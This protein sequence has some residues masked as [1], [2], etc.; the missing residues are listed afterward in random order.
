MPGVGYCSECDRDVELSEEGVCPQGHSP[1]CISDVREQVIASSPA[2]AEPTARD[3]TRT[4]RRAW[5]WIAA[6]GIAILAVAAMAT[7]RG[8]T[9]VPLAQQPASSAT[10][11][12][13]APPLQ[14]SIQNPSFEDWSGATPSNWLLSSTAP[15]E[16]TTERPDWKQSGACGAALQNSSDDECDVTELWQPVAITTGEQYRASVWVISDRQP[17]C[18]QLR[19][20]FFDAQDKM[21]DEFVTAGDKASVDSTGMK[22][23]VVTGTAPEGA[24]AARVILALTGGQH[25]S[26][27]TSPSS[28]VFDDVTFEAGAQ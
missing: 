19:I 20:R 28:A 2:S 22:E 13:A 18:V 12:T 10:Q 17:S 11:Q 14:T 3:A 8:G 6:A 16:M 26:A 1:D 5:I 9:A 21:L 27:P 24:A 4:K 15:G 25:V 7:S 23:I